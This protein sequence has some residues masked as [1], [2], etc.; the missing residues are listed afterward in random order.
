MRIFILLEGLFPKE[1]PGVEGAAELVFAPNENPG[2]E[3]EG[4][5][6]NE[7]P[8][9]DGAELP[10]FAPPNEN[11]PVWYAVVSNEILL[12]WRRK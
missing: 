8:G 2:V 9:V 3:L 1:N 4:V 11:P 12:L 5:F 7:N 10:V 6:P